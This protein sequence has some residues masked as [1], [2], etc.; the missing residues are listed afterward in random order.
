V[1]ERLQVARRL[2]EKF[3]KDKSGFLSENE[4]PDLIKETYNMLGMNYNPTQEDIQSWMQ[5]TD[6]DN[7]GKVNLEDYERLII[8]SLEK[9]GIKIYERE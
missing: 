9:C 6:L 5:M 1:R 7:D 2:F 4:I 8:S 3:D